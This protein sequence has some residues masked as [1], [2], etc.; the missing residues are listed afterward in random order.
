MWS[1]CILITSRNGQIGTTIWYYN[2]Y[3][4]FSTQRSTDYRHDVN[5]TE[6]YNEWPFTIGLECGGRFT[7][8]FK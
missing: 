8:S 1:N 2:M 4:H 6:S 3:T 5:I 7:L